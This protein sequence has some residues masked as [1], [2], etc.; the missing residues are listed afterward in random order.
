MR[1]F[2]TFILRSH[3][4]AIGVAGFFGMVSLH[5]LPFAILSTAALALMVLRHGAWH[6]GV[7]ML[8]AGLPVMAAW[9]GSALKP[10]LDYPLVFALWVPVFFAAIGMR[11]GLGQGVTLMMLTVYCLLCV[12]LMHLITGDVVAFWLNWLGRA[13]AAVPGARIQGF[14]RD[15]TL[16]LMN[17][18]FAVLYL[19][20]LALSLWTGRW[21][22]SL[23][24]HPGGFG[25]EFRA[26][27]LPRPFLFGMVL[28]LSLA[29]YWQYPLLLDWLMVLAASYAT[30]GL[31]LSHAVVARHGLNP[32]WLLPP[33]MALLILPQQIIPG[34]ALLGVID[35]LVD[36]RRRTG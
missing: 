34:L 18:L 22:Q 11:R 21:L 1:D 13:I 9:L 28:A 25:Q 6:G 29:R 20:G 35:S 26:L 4:H 23:L 12:L 5:V 17:G 2:A 7:V 24:Y 19:S 14:E 16:R 36:V 15:G 33:Y 3:L 8:G 30:A 31:A 10:G 27:R 32:H